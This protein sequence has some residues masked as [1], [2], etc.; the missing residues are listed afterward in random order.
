[1]DS[2][3]SSGRTSE[4]SYSARIGGVA[5]SLFGYSA[6]I[7]ASRLAFRPASLRSLFG[8]SGAAAVAEKRGG[9]ARRCAPKSEGEA[10]TVTFSF[11]SAE[12][13]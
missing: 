5:A 6:R 1:V 3:S 13:R 7:G 10:S 11:T 12:T 8:N 2:R 4:F 9:E